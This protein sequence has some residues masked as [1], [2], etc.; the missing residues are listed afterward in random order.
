MTFGGKHEGKCSSIFAG[1]PSPR[2]LAMRRLDPAQEFC[3][4]VCLLGSP[5]FQARQRHYHQPPAS[6]GPSSQPAHSLLATIPVPSQHQPTQNR[7]KTFPASQGPNA[8][9]VCLRCQKSTH[10]ET[11][12]EDSTP[13]GWKPGLAPASHPH[14]PSYPSV[15]LTTPLK[16]ALR[17]DY[18]CF[19]V[20]HA[21]KKSQRLGVK[22]HL[23]LSPAPSHGK[24]SISQRHER[25]ITWAVSK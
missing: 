12:P 14:G 4:D 3:K 21:A 18:W 20:T 11:S 16:L 25:Q 10:L 19:R 2:V 9:E 24:H 5:T 6:Q 1:Q 23:S 22:T 13:G 17:W 7:G 15:V 8:H